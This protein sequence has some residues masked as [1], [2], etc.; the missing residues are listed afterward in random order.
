MAKTSHDSETPAQGQQVMSA[1]AFIHHNFDGAEKVF[2][3][4]R[5]ES[6]KFLPGVYELP[7]GHIDYGEDLIDGL[8]REIMEELEMEVSIG[9]P[10]AVF[11]YLNEVKGSHTIEVVYFGTFVGSIDSIKIH[12]EDH[13][14][15]AWMSR[16]EVVANRGEISVAP[17]SQIDYKQE[18]DPEYLNM[19]KGFDLLEN[20]KINFGQK[21]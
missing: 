13:S 12:P 9:D 2:L 15:Y 6:K 17:N 1:C 19:L 7:G 21:L 4:K 16:E 8:K 11:T 14:G 20:S 3:P 5:A 10:F 18:D